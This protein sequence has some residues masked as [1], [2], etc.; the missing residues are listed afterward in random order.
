MNV[1]SKRRAVLASMLASS[2]PLTAMAEVS[3]LCLGDP[4][5]SSEVAPLTIDTHTHFFN[6]SDLQVREFTAQTTVGPDSELYP[7]VKAMSGVLQTIAW[8]AAPSAA[9][10]RI[11][12]AK[13]AQQLKTCAEQDAW[14]RVADASFES[15]YQLGRRELQ[16]A[17]DNLQRTDNAVKVLGPKS[18]NSGLGAAIAGL[19]PTL[20][21][22]ESDKKPPILQ[23]QPTLAGYLR[24]VLHHF[25]YRHV[26]AIDYLTTYSPKSPRKVDLAVANL[27]DFDYWLT[28][29][30]GTPTTLSDQVELMSEI[31]VLLGGRVHG[32]VPFCPF[33]ETMTLDSAGV[34]DS[35]RLVKQAI[36][37]HGFIGVKLYPPMGFAPMGNTGKTIW[38]DKS[39]LDPAA[40]KPDFGERLDNA[41]GRLFQYCQEND[42]P[43]MAHSNDSNGPYESFRKLAGSS[44]WKQ[45]IEKFPGLRVNFGH[46]GDSDIEDHHGA[47]TLPFLRLMTQEPNST[48]RN[49][50]AD[51]GFFAG[52]MIDQGK[53]RDALLSLYGVDGGIMTERLM[54][55]SDWH[56]I[57]TQKNVKHFLANF[58]ELMDRVEK[59]SPGRNVRQTTL[60]NAFFG[61]NAVEFLGL[62][63]NRGNRTRLE[64]FYA[65]NSVSRP[66]WLRK[67]S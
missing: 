67:V 34:G 22:F 55:G 19:P 40:W 20:S 11:A 21:E 56:M 57:L 35:M 41:M 50:F 36:D 47:E 7:F 46:F 53:M 18:A 45:A 25:N 17:V 59:A 32:F 8:H 37:N 30:R 66:D 43:I 65:R 28:R 51:S 48:G 58:I 23:T 64:R 1:N 3:R 14:R 29:G 39:T 2:A 6:G 15:S 49:V 4:A 44:Y 13:Y 16:L 62:R 52:A 42:V 26:N 10:E 38:K 33:R 61:E 24:F 9:Q 60:A 12:I 63:T 27:V 31:S 54:Y 5:I